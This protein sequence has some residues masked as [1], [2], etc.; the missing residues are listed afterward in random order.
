MTDRK[1]ESKAKAENLVRWIGRVTASLINAVRSATDGCARWHRRRVTVR[2]LWAL[3]DRTLRDIGVRREDI[4]SVA[5]EIHSG[6][7]KRLSVGLVPPRRHAAPRG[8]DGGGTQARR[9][10][11]QRKE[12]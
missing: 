11:N 3:D 1:V 7:S 12:V 2:E 4:Y 9:G 10:S 6:A 5:D 8:M